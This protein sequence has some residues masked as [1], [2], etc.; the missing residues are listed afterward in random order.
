VTDLARDQDELW[1]SNRKI[2]RGI[3]VGLIT[4]FGVS[5]C[6]IFLTLFAIPKFEQIFADALPGKPLPLLT[7]FFISARMGFALINLGWP[8]LGTYLFTKKAPGTVLWINL[9]ILWSILQFGLTVFALFLP[10]TSDGITGMS[11]A[12]P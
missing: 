4:L 5:A 8:I 11:E 3:I 9:G 6:C 7:T 10:M 1:D 2:R 12:K